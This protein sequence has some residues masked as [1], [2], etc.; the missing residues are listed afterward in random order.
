VKG[1]VKRCNTTFLPC[2]DERHFFAYFALTKS[3]DKNQAPARLTRYQFGNHL[4]S[5]SLEFD[6]QAQIISYEE[7]APYGSS[8]YQAVRSQ[9]ETAKRYR[10]TGKERDEETG[11]SHHG[12]R[13][14]SCW[15]ARWSSADPEGP[16]DG[17]NLYAYVRNNPIGYTDQMPE[18]SR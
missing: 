6:E 7:Y 10:Y 17:Q 3:L 18:R 12:A 16:T 5:A 4:G 9:T 2:S 8:T 15:L 1:S 14:Y 13:Y 11:L